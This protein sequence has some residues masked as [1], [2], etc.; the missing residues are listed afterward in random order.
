ML[1]RRIEWWLGQVSAYHCALILPQTSPTFADVASHWSRNMCS[2]IATS[3]AGM[4]VVGSV[5][6]VPALGTRNL[7]GMR[8][9]CEYRGPIPELRL[10]MVACWSWSSLRR[11]IDQPYSDSCYG[12]RMESV[13]DNLTHNKV[14]VS[15][16][17]EFDVLCQTWDGLLN[18]DRWGC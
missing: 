16:A 13:L 10:S 11:W 9:S 15:A 8:S 6:L 12:R 1:L 2:Y 5:W 14:G 18:E 4:S 3:A 17:K 7:L